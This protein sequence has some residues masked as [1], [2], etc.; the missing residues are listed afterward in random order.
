MLVF[1]FFFVEGEQQREA[2]PAVGSGFCSV[3]MVFMFGIDGNANIQQGLRNEGFD[4][5]RYGII[6]FD[7]DI[8]A[9]S[10]PNA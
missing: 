2:N 7:C 4:R 8:K 5:H 3:R 10:Q 9:A 6:N 1:L